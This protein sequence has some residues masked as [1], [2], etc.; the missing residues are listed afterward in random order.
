MA[1]LMRYNYP[2]NVR[3]LKSIISAALNLAQGGPVT[4]D[5]LPEHLRQTNI[6]IPEPECVDTGD[7]ILLADVEKAHILKIY[8]KFKQ[9]KSRTARMLGIGLNTLRRKLA[10]YG[11]E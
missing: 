6:P 5:C 1:L 2:G 8:K 7:S 3:E 4:V 11:V 10:A 9:N